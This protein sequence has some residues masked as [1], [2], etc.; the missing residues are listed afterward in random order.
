MC[1]I[2]KLE[3]INALFEHF[4]CHQNDD[5]F[6]F[7]FAINQDNLELLQK[8]I[9]ADIDANFSFSNGVYVDFDE[10]KLRIGS[11]AKAEL[12][13]SSF[14][15][16]GINVYPDWENFLSYKPNIFSAPDNFLILSD[17]VIYAGESNSSKVNHYLDVCKIIRLL[18]SKA[19][20]VQNFTS[21]IVEEVI[22][23]HKGKLHMPVVYDKRVLEEKLDGFSIVNALFNDDSHTEQ[24]TSI[25]KE[26]I[27]GL[28]LNIPKS[29]RLRYLL[30]NFGE[31]SRRLNEN[32]QL[33]V[34][35][36]SFDDV[37]KEYEEKK[38]EYFIKLNDV[39]SSVQ[40]QMLGIPI[41]IAISSVRM[42][43]V[44]DKVSFFGDL[45]LSISI[46]IYSVMMFVFIKNQK[47]S[48]KAIKND[49][50]SQMA[51]LKH[52][53]ADQY[54]KIIDIKNDLDSRYQYQN[55]CLNGF[56]IITA[57]LFIGTL[58]LSVINFNWH[59]MIDITFSFYSKLI[60]MS[61]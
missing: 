6:E 50:E 12:S 41:S 19:D 53:Y 13:F 8:F 57:L 30:C 51:R 36:F 40:T 21:T 39:F 27:Y 1:I 32:Y 14:K 18:I 20:H 29:E 9:N 55:N 22:F 16:K 24:K 10:I 47:H 48:L 58:L 17:H 34:S 28:L 42:T 26:V 5:G 38:R 11:N 33:F 4:D 59:Y 25:L 23:L 44:L 54:E 60:N 31:F 49:Y 7:S 52:H 56:Y 35:E 3:L 61:N 2:R 45:L 15:V 43:A 37:R 46:I